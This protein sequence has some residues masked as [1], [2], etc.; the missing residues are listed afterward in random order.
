MR[1]RELD[2]KVWYFTGFWYLLCRERE[3][4]ESGPV[5]V[6]AEVLVFY[7]H[8]A[9]TEGFRL[10][11]SLFSVKMNLAMVLLSFTWTFVNRDSWATRCAL[12]KL[13]L[14]PV[15]TVKV[16]FEPLILTLLC[17]HQR[18]C[19]CAGSTTWVE[20]VVTWL[21]GNLFHF[22]DLCLDGWKSA[23]SLDWHCLWMKIQLFKN[24]YVRK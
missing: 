15:F 4:G 23:E 5:L 22:G 3:R 11:M 2:S 17:R 8:Q 14:L 13:F 1:Q 9:W 21:E 19:I 7:H 18:S 10:L 20:S 6:R 24:I 12:C 16:E